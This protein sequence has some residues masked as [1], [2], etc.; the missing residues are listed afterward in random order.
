MPVTFPHANSFSVSDDEFI[1]AW[2]VLTELYGP[3]GIGEHPPLARLNAKQGISHFSTNTDRKFSLDYL[4]R[5]LVPNGYR[6]TMQATSDF[7]NSNDHLLDDCDAVSPASGKRVNGARLKRSVR[8]T[9]PPMYI[10]ALFEADC[11]DDLDEQLPISA[12]SVAIATFPT[13]LSRQGLVERFAD[14]IHVS[15]F[16][17][18]YRG[19][20]HKQFPASPTTGWPA[21]LR[22]YFWPS[23]KTGYSASVATLSPLIVEATRLAN[24][25]TPWTPADENAAVVLANN[26]FKWGGVPQDPRTV[27]PHAIRAVFDAAITGTLSGPRPL[28]NSGWTK[29]AAFASEHLEGT[30]GGNPQVIFDSRVATAI[31]SRLDS[32]LTSAGY[33]SVPAILA[34]LGSVG[35]RGGTR[36][37]TLSLNWS[38]GYKQWNSQFAATRFVVEVRDHLNK[39]LT[40]YGKMPVPDSGG[41]MSEKSWTVRGVEMVL[42]MDGY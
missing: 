29:V 25:T 7:M 8:R 2:Q 42:F 35:G 12:S 23:P 18:W 40:K 31:L 30:P 27:T 32:L 22:E 10:E 20:L 24:V 3:A 1:A 4:C 41:G 13:S 11:D 5:L 16:A 21:R 15:G 39:N 37:R 33:T 26:I 17:T 36:P 19:K 9:A 28:M 6:N 34:D 38:V 14:E